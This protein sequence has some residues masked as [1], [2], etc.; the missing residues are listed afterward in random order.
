MPDCLQVPLPLD[1]HPPGTVGTLL[2]APISSFLWTLS[3]LPSRFL[4]INYDSWKRF[5]PRTPV[6]T[7]DLT[8][9]FL[10]VNIYSSLPPTDL[11]KNSLLATQSHTCLQS[12]G[13]NRNQGKEHTPNEDKTRYQYYT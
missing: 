12:R 1:F 6:A 4:C 2:L 10:L 11:Q 7:L 3:A 8:L 9:P 5:L 13:G